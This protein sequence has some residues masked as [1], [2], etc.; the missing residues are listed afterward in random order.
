MCCL[1]GSSVES[2]RYIPVCLFQ[3][4]CC[5]CMDMLSLALL[6]LLRVGLASLFLFL[7]I[8]G[9]LG[10]VLAYFGILFF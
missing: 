6:H 5:L 9:Q 7:N 2:Y 4:H 3:M 1:F 8:H 10:S